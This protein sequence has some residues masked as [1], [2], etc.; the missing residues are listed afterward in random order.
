MALSGPMSSSGRPLEE[1]KRQSE[2]AW[3]SCKSPG[4]R[5]QACAT[6][7][8]HTDASALYRYSK[9]CY[10]AAQQ[11]QSMNLSV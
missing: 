4:L 6:E 8:L 2:S 3:S 11:S 5:C 7:L 9:D 1:G 10:S